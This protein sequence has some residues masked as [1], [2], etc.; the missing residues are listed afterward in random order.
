MSDYKEDI[1]EEEDDTNTHYKNRGGLINKTGDKIT[2][3][4]IKAFRE[5]IFKIRHPNGE[6]N[7]PW[8]NDAKCKKTDLGDGLAIQREYEW[9]SKGIYNK[10]I[11]IEILSFIGFRYVLD[12]TGSKNYEIDSGFD[13]DG[14]IISAELQPY[15]QEV[16][17]LITRTN[18]D[19]Y[20]LK[21][22]GKWESC[23]IRDIIK[24]NAINMSRN[25]L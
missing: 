6:R 23:Q 11:E 2:E 25:K 13:K 1:E 3:S 14:L 20:Q 9:E 19:E 8:P 24:K 16:V 7:V 4:E 18:K 10:A 12:L 21:Q 22:S 15:E 17:A 5:Q